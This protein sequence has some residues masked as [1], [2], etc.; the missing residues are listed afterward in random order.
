MLQ[1]EYSSFQ[2]MVVYIAVL[3]V[4]I[5]VRTLNLLWLTQLSSGRPWSRPVVESWAKYVVH[6]S[7]HIETLSI[8]EEADIAKASVAAGRII[9]MRDRDHVDGKLISLDVGNIGDD[10]MGVK[11]QFQNVWFRYPTRDVPI[12]NGLNLT[13]SKH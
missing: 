8:N 11:I 5:L 3:Q 13:V 7:P 6:T 4:C 9:D 12:L 2:Y 1:L 10:D